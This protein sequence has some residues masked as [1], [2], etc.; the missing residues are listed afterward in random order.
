MKLP[1]PWSIWG[2]RSSSLVAANPEIQAPQ[3]LL[4]DHSEQKN[5]LTNVDS[6]TGMS[7]KGSKKM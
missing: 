1:I 4:V 5:K 6:G 2:S 7:R 3:K